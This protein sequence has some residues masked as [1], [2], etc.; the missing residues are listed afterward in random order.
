MSRIGDIHNLPRE[1][2]PDPDR[3]PGRP[4][5]LAHT[6]GDAK[7]CVLAYGT[8][9]DTE[10]VEGATALDIRWRRLS[11]SFTGSRFFTARLRNHDPA[12]IGERVGYAREYAGE[13]RASFGAALG[14][15]AGVGAGPAGS[16]ERGQ[17]VSLHSIIRERIGA[18]WAVLVTRPEYARRRRHQVLVPV[19]DAR[20]VDRM[21]GEISS[22][23]GWVA[24]LPGAPAEAVLAIPS[25]FSECE[26]GRPR[27]PGGIVGVVPSRLDAA[28]MREV[29]DALTTY[30]GL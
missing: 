4:W 29:D 17:I 23:A 12:E 16:I 6:P 8:T 15:G 14:I 22:T 3:K 13:I 5:L 30:F 27:R 10:E 28:S 26:S 1:E 21:D 9:Q 2:H 18:R 24:A 19:Y 25:I 20:D 11:G 7:R